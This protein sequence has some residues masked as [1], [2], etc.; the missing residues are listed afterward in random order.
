[1]QYLYDS[2]RTGARPIFDRPIFD[3][4]ACAPPIGQ[5]RQASADGRGFQ[6]AVDGDRG[7]LV[8]D[9][10]LFDLA[11]AVGGEVAVLGDDLVLGDP[12]LAGDLVDL[13][14]ERGDLRMAIEG[15]AVPKE[16][17]IGRGLRLR[18]GTLSSGQGRTMLR[19]VQFVTAISLLAAC[20]FSCST[21]SGAGRTG[22]IELSVSP[23][24]TI[25]IED[26]VVPLPSLAKRLQSDGA[27]PG[28]CI[29]VLV[30]KDLPQAKIKEV[31]GH[32][33]R[34]G[35]RKVVFVTPK[36]VDAYTQDAKKKGRR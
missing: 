22:S 5:C 19:I 21:Q 9:F 24:G 35:F 33:A 3:H 28:T 30:P 26:R 36:Q 29:R 6:K 8:E 2:A 10:V 4:A 11:V 31:A 16:D 34:A 18:Y 23:S 12:E 14:L 32:L 13:V 7:L 1:M 20:G 25:T 17:D 27:G 15:T